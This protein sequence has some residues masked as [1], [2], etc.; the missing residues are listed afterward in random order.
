[1]NSQHESDCFRNCYL[2]SSAIVLEWKPH[3]CSQLIFLISF[4]ISAHT[5]V[6]EYKR[7]EGVERDYLFKNASAKK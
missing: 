5:G 4:T 6:T 7:G 2:S 3:W 1:M